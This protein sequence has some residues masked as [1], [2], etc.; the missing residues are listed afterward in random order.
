MPDAMPRLEEPVDVVLHIGTDKTGT[1]AVQ[2]L[3]ALNRDRLAEA[4]VLYPRSP[5]GRRHVRF[6]LALKPAASLEHHV[7]WQ[8]Q[9]ARSPQHFRR[10]VL[11]R[12]ADEIAGSGAGRVL[13]SDEA[14]YGASGE[15]LRRL[16]RFLDG[17]AR[18]TS[19]VCYLRR[20]DDHL[21]SRYQQQ[22]K[23]GEVRRLA[24]PALLADE[25]GFYDYHGRLSSWTSLVR[26]DEVV[27]RPFEREAFAGGS[28]LAD[29]VEAARLG[30][31]PARLV[32]P[33]GDRNESLD[34]RSVEFLRI[35]NLHRVE[36][37]GAQPRVIDNRDVVRRLR[38]LSVGPTLALPPAVLDGFMAR[39]AA[40]NEAVAREL[41][42][43][44]SGTLF[45]APRKT[46]G[47][48]AEQ[49]LDPARLDDL[50]DAAELAADARAAVR[51]LAEREARER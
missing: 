34:A 23:T 46:A 13:L 32:E 24:D 2:A 3:A 47:T 12:L 48:T 45:H 1:S 43:D 49:L 10:W 42:G 38:P 39:F 11:R 5:G 22:V 26:P 9:R 21:C 18:G 27:V 33:E 17:T 35:L 8:R 40:G 44:P 31:D 19:V 25:R 4:G 15:A 29:F 28:L 51:R 50:L 7:A 14:L 37:E 36:H 20:Q 30:V 6:G 41:V 16:R